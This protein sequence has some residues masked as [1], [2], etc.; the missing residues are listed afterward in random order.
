MRCLIT[1]C[2][3]FIGST[4][5]DRLLAEGHEVVGIDNL[6][7]GRRENCDPEMRLVVGDIRDPEAIPHGDWQIVYHA[8]A[9]YKDGDE[10]ERDASTNVV[11]TI[12][13]VR[14]AMRSAAKI[15]YFQT[16]LTY[17]QVE[18][19]VRID[20]P[21][22]PHGSYAVSKTAGEQYIR[23]SG[24]PWASLRLANMYGPRN[25]S[26]PVPTFFMRLAAGKP[27]TVVDTRRDFVYVADLV[28]LIERVTESGMGVYHAA[29][30]NDQSILDLYRQVVTS[31]GIEA[32]EPTLLPRGPDDAASLLLDPTLTE[33]EFGWV[34]ST[35]FATGIDQTVQWYVANPP[36]TTYTHL[37]MPPS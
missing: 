18:G 21:L 12:N 23:D 28:N 2:A 9:S 33:A 13:V 24:L 7:T 32:P 10:W 26:G 4:L 3:G 36:D 34:A 31:M 20:A 11:G 30:G 6:S 16:A 19:P 27:C 1:G 15:V 17:G 29:S 8:A 14:E 25:L 5:A 22:D 35:P 37:K